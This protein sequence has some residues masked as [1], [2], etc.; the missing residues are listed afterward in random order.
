MARSRDDLVLR[1]WEQIHFLEN[2]SAAYDNGHEAEARRL[3]VALR[4][5]LI[6]TRTSTS[7]FSQLNV[8]SRLQMLD[9]AEPIN[10]RNLA[11]TLG[12]VMLQASADKGAYIP[13]L[14]QSPED[15]RLQP[16]SSWLTQ[17]VCKKGS[18]SWSRERLIT[19]VANQDGGAHVDPDLDAELEE[20]SRRNKMGW[21]F[22]DKD[23][24]RPFTGDFVLASVRQIA[25]EVV[26]TVRR[27]HDRGDIPGSEGG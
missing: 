23:G 13:R 6:D 1:L 3:A 25:Y 9:T 27:H 26:N 19:W 16:L 7:I 12:L 5:L 4:I 18:E 21:E 15:V 10:P 8:L 20:L 22:G 11:P 2:S 24:V 17:P 14:D